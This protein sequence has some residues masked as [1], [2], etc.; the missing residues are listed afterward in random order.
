MWLRVKRLMQGTELSDVDRE[1]RFNNE[2]DQF[3]AAPGESLVSNCL[4]PEWYKYVTGVRLARNVRDK[5]YDELFDYLQQYE[6]IGIA[7]RAKKLEK[8]HD[9][10]ALVAH[11]NYDDDY[12]GDTFQNVSEDTLTSAMMLLVRAI[13]QQSLFKAEML[14]MMVELQEDH[15]IL[16]NSL[17]RVAIAKGHYARDC[18]KL[19]V[20][21]SKYFMELMLL[22]KKDEVG[23]ILSNE[24]NDFF[25]ADVAQ[26]EEI[27]ELSANICMMARIQQANIDSDEGP[28]YDST[29]INEVQTPSTS[30]MIPLFS[31]S[32]HE[33]RYHEQL[34]IINS[35]IGDDQ[36][37][38]DII[39]D[40]L[41]IEVNDG[42]IE[43]DK[44]IHDSHDNELEQLA[45][46]A[47]KEADKQHIL[48][49]KKAIS[50]IP[51][52]YDASYLHSF[53]VHVNVCDIEKILEDATKSHIKME[54]KLKDPIA[55]EKKQNFHPIDYGKLNDL[56]E[57]FVPQ[58]ELSREQTYFPKASTSSGTPTSVIQIVMWIVDSRCSKHMSGNL[59]L[60]KNFI[61]KFIGTVCF[62]K[63]HIAAITRYGD[64]VN[65]TT[66]IWKLLFDPRHVI[67]FSHL[68]DVQ[69]YLNKIMVMTL[70][71]L[72]P[73]L[74]LPQKANL[75]PK[76]V[77]STHSKLELFH[78]DL[79]GPIRVESINVQIQKVRTG[80]G[81]EFKNATPQAHYE[82]LRII[83]QFSIVRTPQQNGVVEK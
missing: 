73:E 71:T 52:L 24:Q 59:K 58:V 21:D 20:W 18:P 40:Y 1:T 16:K 56:Y 41:N 83:Q 76:L 3:T 43:H 14:E 10:L 45:R 32:N 51:K 25:I 65:S 55:I 81:T 70:K 22:V 11:T 77:L 23:V 17:R 39:F 19:R 66:V 12:H 33:Q 50:H 27:E 75:P 60:L 6:K 80:S 9:P 61:E 67:F 13:T 42:S 47:Y 82:K 63:D 30:F 29:F 4:Q 34:K 54:N 31:K 72:A 38:S 53:K 48:A 69:S 7:L 78:M 28:K 62:E 26:M 49:K 37:N 5:P 2:F 8:T 15:T 74:W 68:L 36:I 57:T 35:K 79:C 46:N 64:Y 44:N